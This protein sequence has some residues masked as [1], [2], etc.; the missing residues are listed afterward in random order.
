MDI[1]EDHYL[2][3]DSRTGYWSAFTK[4]H[5]RVLQEK[6]SIMV[7]KYALWAQKEGVWELY[8]RYGKK[9]NRFTYQSVESGIND[10]FIIQRSNHWGIMDPLGNLIT[11]TKYDAIAKLNGYY[12][13][14]YL[15]K[16]GILDEF[17]EWI[18]RA[19]YSKV[20]VFKELF[21]GRK[22]YSYAYFNKD[23]LIRKSTLQPLNILGEALLIKGDSLFGLMDFKG[24]IL[25]EPESEKIELR[26]AFY[27]IIQ[28]S[29]LYLVDQSGMILFGSSLE[30]E[31]TAGLSEELFL[32]KKNGR[33]G[34]FDFEGRLRIG[35]RYD[36][37]QLFRGGQ[38]PVKVNGKW[39]FINKEEQLTIQPY[40][41][42]VS[43][44]DKGFSI[45]R[46]NDRY[47]L[48]DK[49]GNEIVKIAWKEVSKLPTGNFLLRDEYDNVG[50]ISNA[51]QI[52]LRP[53]FA[54]LIDFGDKVIISKNGKQGVLDYTGNQI[55]RIAFKEIKISDDYTILKY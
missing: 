26:N 50:L 7:T 36:S 11:P 35:N 32:I 25:V 5:E 2:L 20:S 22:G 47:G 24:N 19:E 38:A 21:V 27:Q 30:I 44:F 41:D 43:S 12:R 49:T 40:Y 3:K 31:D 15:G 23:S 9:K 1:S 13:V 17:G 51:G 4:Q 39:G 42:E 48:I 45:V 16:Q 6:D 37:A 28:D 46:I 10:Q 53:E 14:N 18:V 52:L 34:F 29:S 33:W 55:F 54:S 8:N